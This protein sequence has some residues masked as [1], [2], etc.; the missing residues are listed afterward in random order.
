MITVRKPAAAQ[1]AAQ[2][3]PAGPPPTIATSN[4]RYCGGEKCAPQL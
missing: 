3:D 4:M 2:L 1:K